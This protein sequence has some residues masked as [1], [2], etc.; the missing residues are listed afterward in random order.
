MSTIEK[1]KVSVIIP[2][3]NR[4]QLLRELIESLWRQTMEP[5]EFE[6]VITDNQSTDGTT[7]MIQELQATSRCRLVYQMMPDNRG[8]AHSRNTAVG[9]SQAEILAF[10]DSDCRV[11]PQW[12]E[13]GTGA[14]SDPNV[15]MV[16]GSV[17]HKP[18]QQVRYFARSH[19]PVLQEHPSYPTMNIFYRRSAFEALGGF[20]EKLCFR[21]FRDRAVECAD[22]DLA[23]RIKEQGRQN[24]FLPELRVYHEIESQDPWIWI[25][26]P[27]K[28][29]VVPALIRRHP[30]LRRTLLRW[31]LF[32]TA[33]N[34]LF[35]LLLLSLPLAIIWRS[36]LPLLVGVP[37]L[38]FAVRACR[39][40]FGHSLGETAAWVVLITARYATM[41]A[42][43]LYGSIRFRRLVL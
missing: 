11:N 18:E 20:D 29:F 39:K 34:A 10:T 31:R 1:P 30:G 14:F 19:D 42:G 5:N 23:W 27:F 35:Y 9:L 21:D 7:E 37:F 36:P 6:I 15:A 12:L 24:V 26:E 32:M 8:P 17:V 3:R 43:L 25:V 28:L 13:V 4:R 40:R 16:S 41:C 38:Y 22:T 33:L 2:T